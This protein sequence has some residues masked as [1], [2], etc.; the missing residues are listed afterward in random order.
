MLKKVGRYEI[1]AEIGRGGM[2]TVYRAFDPEFGRDVAVKILPREFLHDPQFR[3]RFERE[4]KT[5]AALEHFA[6]VPLYDLGEVDGQPYTVARFMAG[7][8][9]A[10]HISKGRMEIT[11]VVRIISRVASALDAANARGIVH[12]DLKPSNVLLDQ[13]GGVFLSDFGIARL[14]AMPGATLTGSAIIGSPPYMSPEQIEGDIELD[15][16]SDVYALGVILFEMLTGRLPYLTD[17]PTQAIMAHLL[18]PIPSLLE[19]RPDLPQGIEDIVRRAMAKNREE[20]FDTAGEMAI[21]FQ[22]V[23]YG[24]V[25]GVP[26]YLPDETI[27]IQRPSDVKKTIRRPWRWVAA[28]AGL[29]IVLGL[30]GV[31]GDGARYFS[32]FQSVSPTIAGTSVEPVNSNVPIETKVVAGKNLTQTG[33]LAV[34]T[35]TP[36]ATPAKPLVVGGAD[37]IAFL[38]DNNVWVVNVDGNGLQQITDDGAPKSYLRWGIEGNTVTYIVG[39]C[40]ISVNLDSGDSQNLICFGADD[41]LD[42]FEISPDQKQVAIGMYNKLYIIAYDLERFKQVRFR[43]DLQDIAPCQYNAPNSI[44]ELNVKAARWSNDAKKLAVITEGKGVERTK[45]VEVIQVLDVS[46]CLKTLPVLDQFPTTLSEKYQ[47]LDQRFQVRGYA[48]NPVIENFGWDGKNKFVFVG[49]VQD[50]GY[51]TLNVYH[52]DS[53]KAEVDVNPVENVCCYRDPQWSPDGK[54]LFWV[55]KDERLGP[56][57]KTEFY[58]IPYAALGTGLRFSALPFEDGFFVDL[59]EKHQAVL[60]PAVDY[61]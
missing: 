29:V 28:L 12:R 11:D 59:Q 13:Y 34:F 51:G 30:L 50:D 3:I 18:E 49:V 56:G 46:Q 47:A 45:K 24:E 58:Y 2:S 10:E 35:A 61:P 36:L 9:L 38:K 25:N 14:T 48:E 42:F 26:L 23:L 4:A 33:T 16:R 19:L 5:I 1:K 17:S 7:G 15:G 55:F 21:A 40:V 53:G 27:R 8:T 32:T 39:K 31:F 41:Q 44:N 37:K 20:R 57:A 43:S 54:F 22:A 6:I 60:R 52:A